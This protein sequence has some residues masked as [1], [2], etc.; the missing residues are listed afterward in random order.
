MMEN[1]L[2]AEILKQIEESPEGRIP[3]A[4]YM[5]LALYHP[6]WGYYQRDR[7]KLGREGDFFTNAHVGELYGLVL[8][9]LYAKWIRRFASV[10]EWAVVEM[11]AGDGRLAEQVGKGLCDAGI[12]PEQIRFHLV[13]ISPFHRQSARERLAALPVSYCIHRRLPEIPPVKVAFIYSNELVDAFPVHRIKKDGGLLL[14]SWVS[15]GEDRKLAEKWIPLG[16]DSADL[17]K[18]GSDLRDG[19]MLEVP[20]AA[21]GWLQEVARWL[22]EGILVTIDYGASTRVLKQKKGTLRGY[23]KHRV[24]PDIL[25]TPG[26]ID[27]TCDVNFSLLEEWGESEGLMMVANLTQAEFLLQSGIAGLLPAAVPT[28]PFS[29][30]A[31]RVRA[32]KQL[33]HPQAMGESFRILIQSKGLEINRGQNLF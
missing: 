4:Q 7:V 6:E 17:L 19:E 16:T 32:I 23:R 3:F 9:R 13:E 11:G 15:K 8:G 33:I 31:K 14:E 28:D 27:L 29:P 2:L 10:G 21:R 12:P 24:I 26:E 25:E 30:E 1:P 20:L 22:N 5:E 18:L